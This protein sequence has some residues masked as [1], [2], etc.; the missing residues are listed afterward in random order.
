MAT[1]FTTETILKDGQYVYYAPEGAATPW[2]QRK[3]IARFKH[4]GPVTKAKFIKSLMKNY[5]VESYFAAIEKG[6]AP[7]QILMDDGHLVFHYGENN[8]NYFV[9]DGKVI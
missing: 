7:T 4:R 1:K 3:F 9:L 5:T 8:H 6:R 2:S